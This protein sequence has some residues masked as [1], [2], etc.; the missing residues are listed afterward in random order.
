MSWASDALSAS[1]PVD[2][3]WYGGTRS[4]T[5]TKCANTLGANIFQSVIPNRSFLEIGKDNILVIPQA[6]RRLSVGERIS[7][8]TGGAVRPLYDT[9][10]LMSVERVGP[11]PGVVRS[12]P[13][14]SHTAGRT[15]SCPVG[16][17]DCRTSFTI[18]IHSEHSN[19][20][21]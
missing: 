12:S 3:M 14:T 16:S 11:V 2:F 4:A 7:W 17:P 6:G 5:S 13:L 19:T 1:F 20:I 18:S 15:S 21:N 9:V 8:C 10:Y